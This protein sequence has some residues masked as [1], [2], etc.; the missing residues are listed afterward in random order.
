MFP[1]PET[2][3]ASRVDAAYEQLREQIQRNELAPGFQAPEP[4][5]ASQL[6]M[7]R[8]PVREA[9]LRLEAEGFVELIPRRGVRVLPLSPND[10]KDI[11]QILTCLESEAAAQLATIGLSKVQL[12]ELEQATL[13]MEAA[14]KGDNLTQWANA[15]NRFHSK[16]LE[17]NG[18]QRLWDVASTLS[19]QSHR[20]RMMTLRLR[21]LPVNSSKEHRAIINAIKKGD[22]DKARALF[23]SHREESAN[24]LLAILETLNLKHL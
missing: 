9:L 21:K 16:V 6:G 10:M 8:T 11:Y 19:N 3:K 7:S 4:E 2:K 14:L 15:D 13:D 22:A 18:N 5:I 23:R 1:K 12:T 20:A 17:F 24:E